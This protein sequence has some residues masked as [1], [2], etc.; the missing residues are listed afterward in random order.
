MV[1]PYFPVGRWWSWPIFV[2]II[3]LSL[4]LYWQVSKHGTSSHLTHNRSLFSQST[5]LTAEPTTK[6]KCT[7]SKCN[8]KN[9]PESVHIWGCKICATSI[10]TRYLCHRASLPGLSSSPAWTACCQVTAQLTRSCVLLQITHSEQ[11]THHHHQ[12][13]HW[14]L[15]A[16]I[17]QLCPI[18]P[19]KGRDVKWS[20]SAIYV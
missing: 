13:C 4:A 1:L 3:Y 5:A 17:S 19:L 9:W 20:H 18:N 2:F 12:P 15:H 7:K 16:V 11:N 8:T 14:Q 6:E 10:M